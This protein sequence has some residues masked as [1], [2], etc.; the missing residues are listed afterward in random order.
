MSALAI[1][2]A[3]WAMMTCEETLTSL[4][5]ERVDD[6]L[7]EDQRH[8]VRERLALLAILALRS[9]NTTT[10]RNHQCPDR[11]HESKV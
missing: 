7:D 9:V 2:R 3:A 11:R 4:R 5:E 8:G 1:E 10:K 6:A